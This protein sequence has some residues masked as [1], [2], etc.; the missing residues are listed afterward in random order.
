MKT[1]IHDSENLE[2]TT[3]TVNTKTGHINF[4]AA[5]NPP[6]KILLKTDLDNVTTNNH[7]LIGGDLNS[8]NTIWKNRTTNIIRRILEE[9]STEADYIVLAPES[10]TFYPGNHR[11]RPDVLDVILTNLKITTE[12]LTVLQEMD[13]DHN[14]VLC[15]WDVDT[16]HQTSW[17]KPNRLRTPQER[18]KY[19]R[20]KAQVKRTVNTMRIT[21]WNNFVK[22][23]VTSL[24]KSW[25]LTKILK[26]IAKKAGT[27]AIHG[28]QGMAYI[29]I[30]K[31]NA[32]ALTPKK[33]FQP[34]QVQDAEFNNAHHPLGLRRMGL[35]SK[36]PRQQAT[37]STEQNYQTHNW[38]GPK[39]KN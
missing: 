22:D 16:D 15:E 2:A 31:A 1:N 4:V 25:T 3:V 17:H 23:T 10:P 19:N 14:P 24:Q 33:Q 30:D 29:S 32:I 21:N 18:S 37:N 8:K 39:N 7:L 34:N 9:H 28:Q 38:N 5:Y 13:S 36:D 11:Y 6:S 20:L 26:G 35:R 27:P 12:S